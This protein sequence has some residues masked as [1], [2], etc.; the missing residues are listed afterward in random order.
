MKKLTYL[1]IGTIVLILLIKIFLLNSIVGFNEAAYGNFAN[2]INNGQIPY[3]DFFDHKPPLLYYTLAL[4][5]KIAGY[6]VFTI[7]LLALILNLALF[8]LMFF[9]T[10][11]I[12]NTEMALLASSLFLIFSPTSLDTEIP[13]TFFG[14][15]GIY[16]YTFKS[17]RI[18]LLLAG[19]F[20]AFSIWFKQPGVIFFI[21]ILAHQ[22]YLLIKKESKLKDV[23]KEVYIILAGIL[24]ISI[25]LLSYFIYISGFENFYFAIIKFNALFDGS[26]SRILQI[27]KVIELLLGFW[28]MLALIAFSYKDL[29][30]KQIQQISVILSIIL[31]LFFFSSQE[32]FIN[33][34]YQ[35]LPFMII[36]SMF[37]LKD[38]K[39]KNLAIIFLILFL[40]FNSFLLLEKTARIY[41]DKPQ[42]QD[43]EIA[44]FIKTN[45]SS[46]FSSDPQYYFTTEKQCTYKIC[47][48]APSVASVFNFSDFCDYAKT[49]NCLVL[50]HR[51][52]YLGQ[53]AIDCI[54]N[55]FILIKRFDNIGESYVDILKKK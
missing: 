11:K 45:C 34:L 28:P 20:I 9:I 36:L 6:S 29:F 48:L 8:F 4:F 1:L 50:S 46:I 39:I 27:G 33:H 24:I 49:Q 55:N 22:I 12:F 42:L 37:S 40:L 38:K 53:Q 30:K 13:M 26:T 16:F 2:S 17:K 7:H 19:I 43:S 41:R 52:K 10:K 23:F 15:L 14:L 5:F 51:E 18:Y 44:D 47:Y 21:A 32:I 54:D 31:I 25:P 35:I 3:Q